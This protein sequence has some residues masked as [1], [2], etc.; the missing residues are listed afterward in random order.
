MHQFSDLRF[1]GAE[2]TFSS[3]SSALELNG[4]SSGIVRCES[5]LKRYVLA[6]LLSKEEASVRDS[7]CLKQRK[8]PSVLFITYWLFS[9]P[10]DCMQQI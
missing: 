3:K 4:G 10:S 5:C 8:L 1:E 2:G 7:D 6:V 9:T